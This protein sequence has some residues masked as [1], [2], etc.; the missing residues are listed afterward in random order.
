MRSADGR[1]LYYEGFLEDITELK[2]SHLVDE[3][4]GRLTQPPA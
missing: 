4:A 3:R 2:L 1:I